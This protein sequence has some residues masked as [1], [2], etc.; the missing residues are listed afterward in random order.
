M[1]TLAQALVATPP[2]VAAFLPSPPLAMTGTP[3]PWETFARK[4]DAKGKPRRS[5]RMIIPVLLIPVSLDW[6]VLTPP[7][8]ERV[9][10]ETPVR[11]TTP[12]KPGSVM[13]EPRPIAM[14]G[15]SAPRTVVTPTQDA[16]T[17]HRKPFATMETCARTMMLAMRTGF[18]LE[19][20]RGVRMT[21]PAPRT[22]ACRS[23]DAVMDPKPAPVKMGMP[24]SLETSAKVK[25]AFLEIFQ[26]VM[27]PMC[28]PSTP[29]M[30][31]VHAHRPQWPTFVMTAMRV[32]PP[33]FAKTVRAA[34]HP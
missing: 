8:K 33:V 28:A 31:M 32:H 18:A 22:P 23:P 21:T 26:R 5:A 17:S 4:E 9:R 30:K 2:Q 16:H 7:E 10:M 15:T 13:E 27:T 11:K 25:S 34:Q 14:M 19:R 24:V 1:A 20:F 12:V 6:A 29:A 3:V